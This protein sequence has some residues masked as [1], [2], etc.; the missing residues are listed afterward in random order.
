M[1]PYIT[2]NHYKELLLLQERKHRNAQHIF[3]V[4]GE[5]TVR[6]G[7]RSGWSVDTVVATEN[8]YNKN[9]SWLPEKTLMATEEQICRLSHLATSP[10]VVA[11]L[12]M[13]DYPNGGIGEHGQPYLL[14]DGITD[15]GN[16]GTLIRTADWFGLHDI[17]LTGEGVDPYNPKVVRGSMGS[18]FRIRVFQIPEAIPLVTDLKKKGYHIITTDVREGQSTSKIGASFCLVL[19]S[20]A[21][22]VTESIAALADHRYHIPGFGQAESL[23][24]AVSGGIAL[25]DLKVVR[26]LY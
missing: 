22:G 16:V 7:L 15:P 23:N 17:I 13:P 1:P 2:K 10:G 9:I 24:V 6:E 4:D 11:A 18:L 8:F 19:G 14:L 26:N 21:H 20:E 25:F 5:K 3:L 12:V